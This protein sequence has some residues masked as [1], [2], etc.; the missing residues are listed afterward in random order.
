MIHEWIASCFDGTSGWDRPDGGGS[1][2]GDVDAGAEAGPAPGCG[3]PGQPCCNANVCH[4]N[5]CCVFGQC[6]GQGQTC[7]TPPPDLGLSG[8]CNNGSCQNMAG[9]TCGNVGQ[10]CCEAS[11]CTA[12][13]VS[14]LANATT[15]SACGGAD[16]A[17]CKI[18]SSQVCIDGFTCIGGG[19]NKTG[20]CQPCGASGQACCGSGTAAQKT[21]DPGLTCTPV[22]GMGTLCQP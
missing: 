2:G 6:R 16:Q 14:C 17:C 19:V 3:D 15:C 20:N 10:P 22:L 1:D 21:C 12:S 4:N 5:G 7:T 18:G 11:S 9:A 13:L 8:T